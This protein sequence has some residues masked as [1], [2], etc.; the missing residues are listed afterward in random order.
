MEFFLI[1]KIQ[2]IAQFPIAGVQVA[3]YAWEPRCSILEVAWKL[4]EAKRRTNSNHPPFHPY[5][6]LND[7]DLK[8]ERYKFKKYE[9]KN[10]LMANILSNKIINLW[11]SASSPHVWYMRQNGRVLRKSIMLTIY[12]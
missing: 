2:T 4:E 11:L 7:R 8:P 6:T 10:L 12:T 5:N 1:Q 9:T 3:G